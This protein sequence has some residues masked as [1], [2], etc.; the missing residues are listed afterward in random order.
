[1]TAKPL[2]IIIIIIITDP[3]N[4]IVRQQEMREY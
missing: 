2:I 4:I 1:M 3:F